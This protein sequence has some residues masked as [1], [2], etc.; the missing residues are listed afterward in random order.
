M[1]IFFVRLFSTV[2]FIL[3]VAGVPVYA[4]QLI[5]DAELTD[6]DRWRDEVC[7]NKM[8]GQDDEECAAFFDMVITVGDH[9]NKIFWEIEERSISW[10]SSPAGQEM[11]RR[12]HNAAEIFYS[13]RDNVPAKYRRTPKVIRN[14]RDRVAGI[15][16]TNPQPFAA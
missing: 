16:F 14:P 5:S 8:A 2:F 1:A 13:L 6:L 15:F 9:A 7:F 11:I 12:M 4:G 10:R 3:C